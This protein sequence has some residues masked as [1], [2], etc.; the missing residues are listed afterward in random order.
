MHDLC[1]LR[2]F[3]SETSWMMRGPLSEPTK[4]DVPSVAHA[5]AAARRRQ[6]RLRQFLRHE[7]LTVAMLLAERDH[8]TALR[9]QTQARSGEEVRVARHGQ[10]PEQPPPQH[11]LF[12]LYEAEPGGS[13]PPC[14]GEPRGSSAPWSSSPTSCP[15]SRF[16]TFLCHRW[17]T[18]WWLPSSTL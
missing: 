7:R 9:G 8:H 14:L 18:S 16:W 6:R 5:T 11:E 4:E 2:C 13:H 15:W 1:F 12:Q 10:V 17:G 3:Q